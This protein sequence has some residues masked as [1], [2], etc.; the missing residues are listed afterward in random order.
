MVATTETKPISIRLEAELLA[1]LRQVARYESYKRNTDVSYA[2]LIR[3]A[4]LQ[5]YPLP[6]Q[7]GGTDADTHKDDGA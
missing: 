2:D 3:E 4:V 7:D 5:V 6:I 1:H